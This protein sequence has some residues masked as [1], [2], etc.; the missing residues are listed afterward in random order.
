MWRLLSKE[1]KHP[2]PCEHHGTTLL[3]STA[4]ENFYSKCPDISQYLVG[5][6]EWRHQVNEMTFLTNPT[7]CPISHNAPFRAEMCIFLFWIV[8]CGTWD[9][10]WGL[11]NWSIRNNDNQGNM[12]HVFV[13]HTMPANGLTLWGAWESA[14]TKMGNVESVFICCL[15]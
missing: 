4:S 11:W 8:H 14:C 15:I 5:H 3:S 6:Y 12:E 1:Q 2:P 10:L 7:T 9:I 13:V